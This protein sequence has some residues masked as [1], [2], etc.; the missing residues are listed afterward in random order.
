[1]LVA[2]SS[3][4][5]RALILLLVSFQALLVIGKGFIIPGAGEVWHTLPVMSMLDKGMEFR[6]SGVCVLGGTFACPKPLP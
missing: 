5:C 3:S 1:M 6:V 2:E 4:L